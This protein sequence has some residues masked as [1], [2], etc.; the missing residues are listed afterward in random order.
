MSLDRRAA[1][2]LALAGVAFLASAA[3]LIA[4][5]PAASDDEQP[6]I[7]GP[8]RLAA[9]TGGFVDSRDLAG[10]PFGIYFGFTHCPVICPTTLNQLSEDLGKLGNA[11]KDLRIF[12]VTVD[13]ERDRPEAMQD[14]LSSFDARVVGLTPTPGELA[15]IARAWRIT[16]QKVPTSDGSYTMD[17]TAIVFLMDRRGGLAATLAPDEAPETRLEKLRRLVA[18]S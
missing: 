15:D 10:H 3:Y 7:G 1:L 5:R 2:G 13:P 12:F 8:F 6:A 9:S 11:G 16:Y 17:H 4:R 14:Y 18:A